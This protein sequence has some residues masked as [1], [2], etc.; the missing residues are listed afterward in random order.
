MT[1][2]SDTERMSALSLSF[3]DPNQV[4]IQH[5]KGELLC[6]ENPLHKLQAALDK[7]KARRI[8]AESESSTKV[9]SLKHDK[10]LTQDVQDMYET[11]I[12]DIIQELK[13]QRPNVYDGS[14]KQKYEQWRAIK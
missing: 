3:T 8:K 6:K 13:T 9:A 12:Y 1:D 7:E 5:N 11:F 10:E 2:I 4:C 14:I